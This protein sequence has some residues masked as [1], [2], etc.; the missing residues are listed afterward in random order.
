MNYDYAQKRHWRRTMWNCIADRVSVPKRDALTLYLAGESDED[1][2]VATAKGFDRDNLIAVERDK[3]VLKTLRSR[4][5]LALHGDIF[6]QVSAWRTDRQIDVLVLDLVCGLTDKVMSNVEELL[7][8]PQLQGAVIAINMCRGREQTARDKRDQLSLDDEWSSAQVEAAISNLEE[9]GFSR[10]E[11]V[12]LMCRVGGTF[13]ETLNRADLLQ[14]RLTRVMYAW[15]CRIKAGDLS[16]P[17][18]IDAADLALRV[19]EQSRFRTLSYRSIKNQTYDTLIWANSLHAVGLDT[20]VVSSLYEKTFANHACR[21]QHA[22]VLAHR[23][24]RIKERA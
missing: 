14:R 16:A 20:R 11:A 6:D 23:T 15:C 3:G 7:I 9:N 24:R 19:V 10:Q 12:E 8:C 2:E 22:A 13:G 4:G 1:R 18:Q 17:A 5:V 21:R